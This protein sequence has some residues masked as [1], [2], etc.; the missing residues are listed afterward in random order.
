[1]LLHAPATL[2]IRTTRT[3]QNSPQTVSAAEIHQTFRYGIRI[4]DEVG[5]VADLT[6]IIDWIRERL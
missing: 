6:A 1:M 3:Q 4:D 2:K 5:V